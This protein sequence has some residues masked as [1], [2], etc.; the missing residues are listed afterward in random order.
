V[1]SKVTGKH[2]GGF[3]SFSGVWGLMP[4]KVEASVLSAEIDMNSI[5][6]DNDKLTGH[7]KSKDFFDVA[8]FQV[9]L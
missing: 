1:G 7:L 6:A 2:D 5:W 3:K 4:E 8:S 9:N